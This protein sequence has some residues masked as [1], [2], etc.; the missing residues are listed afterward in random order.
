MR[1]ITFIALLSILLTGCVSRLGTF[2]MLAPRPVDW[3]RAGEFQ[4]VE[5][6]VKG[7]DHLQIIVVVPTKTQATLETATENALA[8]VPGAVALQD[9]DVYARFFYIP[10]IYGESGYYVEGTVVVDP[11]KK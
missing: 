3:S 1:T 6:R 4:K 2:H 8:Q 9:A 11:A 10:F 7:K 5:Q